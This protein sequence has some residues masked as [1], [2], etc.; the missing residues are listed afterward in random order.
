MKV[1]VVL[2]HQSQSVYKNKG[3]VVKDDVAVIY[4]TGQKP[5]K[6]WGEDNISCLVND[7]SYIMTNLKIRHSIILGTHF[8]TSP[9]TV[10]TSTSPVMADSPPRSELFP[11]QIEMVVPKLKRLGTI[12]RFFTCDSSS[13]QKKWQ[14]CLVHQREPYNGSCA[15]VGRSRNLS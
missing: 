12:D 2:G 7:N 9:H 8:T 11:R 1:K 14:M 13:C 6:V 3:T 15:K 5:L 10:I 4:P